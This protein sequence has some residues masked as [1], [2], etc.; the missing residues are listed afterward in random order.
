[1]F[2]TVARLSRRA[3]TTPRRSPET[4]VTPAL[5]IATSVPVPM[6]M[7]TSAG[8]RRRIV[9]PVSGHRHHGAR[10]LELGDE[11]SLS[12]RKHTGVHLGDAEAPGDRL[13]RGRV[14]SVAMITRIRSREVRQRAAG[15]LADRVLDAESSSGA[16]VDEDEG[17]GA[18]ALAPAEGDLEELACA[19]EPRIDLPSDHHRLRPDAPAHSGARVGTKLAHRH[20]SQPTRPCAGHDGSGQRMLA[21]GLDRGRQP[22]DLRVAVARDAPDLG[23]DRP[24]LGEGAGLIHHQRVHLGESLQGRRVPEQHPACAPRPVPT[25]TAM[26]SRAPGRRG[27]R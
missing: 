27:R 25:M 22:E 13:R 14:V 16:S 1:M 12:L 9:H 23:E 21:P 19:G 3:R 2:R 5:C 17:H 24:S 18:P 6:A 20:R 11:R 4:S 7:P 10:L 15:R 26:E 8:Q